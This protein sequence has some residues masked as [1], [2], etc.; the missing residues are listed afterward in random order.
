M[1]TKQSKWIVLEAFLEGPATRKEAWNRNPDKLPW[2]TFKRVCASL[3]FDGFIETTTSTF[4]SHDIVICQLTI[5]G[6]QSL[7]RWQESK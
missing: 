6:R 4:A 1:K 7:K 2:E 5:K 3:K